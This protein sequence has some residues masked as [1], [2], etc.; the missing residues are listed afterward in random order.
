MI[1]HTEEETEEGPRVADV[2]GRIKERLSAL[3]VPRSIR[4][5]PYPALA[6]AT[7]VGLGLGIVVGSRI[8][9]SLVLSVGMSVVAEQ[10]RRYGRQLL[11]E[12]EERVTH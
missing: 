1:Q 2:L 10:L 7:A 3:D 9:R 12:G 5:N 6:V 11:E 4:E 8:V